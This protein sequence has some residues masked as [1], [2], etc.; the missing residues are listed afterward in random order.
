MPTLPGRPPDGVE[1]AR[2]SAFMG[3]LP[4]AARQPMKTPISTLVALLWLPGILPAAETVD[5]ARDIKPLLSR[6]CAACHGALKQKAGLRLDTAARA[7]QGGENGPAIVAGN[8]SE[9]LLVEAVTGTEGWRM[10]PEGE[11]L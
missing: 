5:Y 9:S 6:R 3:D 7:R 10:P 4:P 8:S 11:P 2:L 1:L